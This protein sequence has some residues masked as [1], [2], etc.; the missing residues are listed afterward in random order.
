MSISICRSKKLTFGVRYAID[1]P[2][3]HL[4]QI[5]SKVDTNNDGRIDYRCS[6]SLLL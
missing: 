2:E 6:E 5:V 1:V 3:K 4:M